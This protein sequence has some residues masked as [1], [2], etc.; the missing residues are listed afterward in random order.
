MRVSVLVVF[1]ALAPPVMAEQAAIQRAI[2]PAPQTKLLPLKGA[3]SNKSCAAYGPGFVKIEGTDTCMHV[4]GSMSIG[5]GGT[6][7]GR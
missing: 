1:L 2:K 6:T 3:A 7:T 5:A 4:G